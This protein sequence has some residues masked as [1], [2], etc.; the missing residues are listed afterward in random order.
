MVVTHPNV[1][2]YIPGIVPGCVF[3]AGCVLAYDK[4]GINVG[5]NGL[6]KEFCL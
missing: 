3:I 4:L 1:L 6:K 5:S 2:N